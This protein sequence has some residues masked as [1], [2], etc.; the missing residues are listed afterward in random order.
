M[1]ACQW[2]PPPDDVPPDDAP[3]A[4]APLLLLD[5]APD[6]VPDVVPVELDGRDVDGMVPEVPVPD[7]PVLV[8]LLDGDPLTTELYVVLLDPGVCALVSGFK[9]ARSLAA[10]SI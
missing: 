8:P 1:S 4:D 6:D 2:L 5:A 9:R 3:P 7:V 10:S